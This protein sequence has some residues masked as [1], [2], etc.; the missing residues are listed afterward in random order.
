MGQKFGRERVKIYHFPLRTPVARN[1]CILERSFYVPGFKGFVSKCV[2]ASPTKIIHLFHIFQCLDR[3]MKPAFEEFHL[4]F[5]FAL[6][7]ISAG[8][9]RSFL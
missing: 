6:S 4:W 5:Q 9:V 2:L 8:K 7:V 1:L 3:G